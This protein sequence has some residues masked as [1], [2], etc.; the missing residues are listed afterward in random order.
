MILAASGKLQNLLERYPTLL[1]MLKFR[2][3]NS[4][5]ENGLAARMERELEK[6]AYWVIYI[7]DKYLLYCK[8]F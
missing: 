5:K 1:S 6:R 8:H 7:I 3:L 2:R 4:P